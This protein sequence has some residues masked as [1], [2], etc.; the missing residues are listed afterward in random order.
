MKTNKREK[1][2]IE[3]YREKARTV[4]KHHFEGVKKLKYLSSGLTNFVFGCSVKEGDF[5]IRISP[6]PHRLNQFIKEQWAV[7]AA[8]AEGIPVAEILEVGAELIGS[9]YMV[10]RKI[11]GEDAIHHPKRLKVIRELGTL[12]AKINSIKTKGFGSTFDWSDNKLSKCGTFEEWL[13]GEFGAEAKLALLRKHRLLTPSGSKAIEKILAK[14]SK[15]RLKPVLNH[16]DL[17]LKNVIA[18][19]DGKILALIDWEGC[20]SNIPPAWELSIALH[21]LGIDAKQL[22]IEGYG[23]TPKKLRDL[24]P[25]IRAYNITNYATTVD[26]VAK[27]KRLLEYYRLRIDGTFDLYSI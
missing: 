24:I 3:R 26:S 9:P 8:K 12:A 21:D 18:D 13:Y 22:F 10:T 23:I 19:K 14:A 2:E 1:H 11:D 7:N 5:I 20:T 27:D 16:G 15:S 4:I 6:D 25:L 17:R